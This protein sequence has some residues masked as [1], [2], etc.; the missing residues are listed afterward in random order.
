M[1]KHKIIYIIIFCLQFQFMQAQVDTSF[2]RYNISFNEYLKLVS[3][4][5]LGY[6]AEKL[7]VEI[8]DAAIEMAKV[9][10]DP[11]F[12]F[13][14]NDNSESSTRI[15]YDISSELAST[16]ELGGKRRARIDLAKSENQLIK[17]LIADYFRNLQA[18]AAIVYLE[19]LKQKYLFKVKFDSYITIKHLSD[20]DS[21]RFSLG[22]I[23][24]IDAAQSKV[25]AGVLFNELIQTEAEW[26]NSLTQI[27]FMTGV[28]KMDTLYFPSGSFSNTYREFN[29]ENLISL[30]MNNRSDLLVA[31]NNKEVSQ[32]AFQLARKERIMD[33]DMNIGIGN[34]YIVSG[35]TPTATSINA[36][37]AIPLKFSNFNKGELK[38]AQLQISQS[39]EL[40]KQAEFQIQCEITQALQFYNACCKQVDNFEKG[41][42]K[43]AE[44]VKRGKIY[45]YERGE[46]SLLEVL[47]AQRT[48]ND[49]QTAYYEALYNKVASLVE[50][51]KATGIWDIDL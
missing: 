42:L 33:I 10:P 46:T 29:I 41:M 45:S 39:E 32:K 50:L 14:W 30:A 9:F 43:N 12:S 49:I 25:E 24:E 31:L 19:S 35:G 21:V 23:M 3:T 36:G 16:I 11:I 22:S 15:G 6:V 8:S 44:N 38:I 26:K 13:N 18:E 1:K 47:N 2:Q 28:S 34:S 51:E 4:H 27:A 20:A 48:Y 7:N 40:Y 5:N 37:I 17:A